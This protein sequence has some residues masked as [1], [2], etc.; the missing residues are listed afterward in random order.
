[1]KD[2]ARNIPLWSWGT[3]GFASLAGA[4]DVEIGKWGKVGEV[5][6]AREPREEAREIT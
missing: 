6:H 3:G 2:P 5:G 4:K 1:M